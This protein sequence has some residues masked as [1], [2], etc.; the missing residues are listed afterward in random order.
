MIGWINHRLPAASDGDLHGMVR[1]GPQLPGMLCRWQEVRKGEMW[2][3][4]SAWVADPEVK[5]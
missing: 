1:W 2:T 4:S 3:H 5:R